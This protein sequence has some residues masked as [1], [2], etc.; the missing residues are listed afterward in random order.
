MYRNGKLYSFWSSMLPKI[1]MTSNKSC[2]ELN[3][4]AMTKD[5][6]ASCSNT[7]QWTMKYRFGSAQCPTWKS[8]RSEW[9]DSVLNLSWTCP[10]R[11]A[12]CKVPY[13]PKLMSDL[14]EKCNIGEIGN[15]KGLAKKSLSERIADYVGAS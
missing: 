12:V 3:Y 15:F 13:H 8:T 6:A 9:P 11:L 2:S 4:S 5:N 1:R 14:N 7:I 10:A